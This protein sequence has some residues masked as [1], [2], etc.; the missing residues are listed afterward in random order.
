M[1]LNYSPTTLITIDKGKVILKEGLNRLNYSARAALD[2]VRSPKGDYALIVVYTDKDKG[3]AIAAS[4][5][6]FCEEFQAEKLEKADKMPQTRDAESDKAL[7]Q[8]YTSQKLDDKG[9][10]IMFLPG[11]PC[12][13]IKVNNIW[14]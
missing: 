8:I 1:S 14:K 13:P 7:G 12:K 5:I 9:S 6:C 4:D 3:I 11:S 2:R 10:V